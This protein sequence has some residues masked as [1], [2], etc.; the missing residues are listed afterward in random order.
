MLMRL[1]TLAPAIKMTCDSLRLRSRLCNT[2]GRMS[3]SKN[4]TTKILYHSVTRFL[5]IPPRALIHGLKPFCIWLNET[6]ENDDKNFQFYLCI[7][8]CSLPEPHNY[9]CRI[10]RSQ[11]DRWIGSR[12]LNETAEILW[13]RGNP[14]KNEYWFLFSFKGFIVKTNTY[15]NIVYL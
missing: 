8:G 1:L 6:T 7:F 3:Y 15:V 2:A 10:L 5:T 11:W 4:Q 12:G 9:S 14:Y 13:H